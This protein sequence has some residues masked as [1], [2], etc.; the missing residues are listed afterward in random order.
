MPAIISPIAKSGNNTINTLP[1]TATTT[2]SNPPTIPQTRPKRAPN[3]PNIPPIN[4]NIKPK[5]PKPRKKNKKMVINKAPMIFITQPPKKLFSVIY[6]KVRLKY[7][8]SFK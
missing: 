7:N 3:K 1:K 6:Y 5:P 4:P 2:P 8:D